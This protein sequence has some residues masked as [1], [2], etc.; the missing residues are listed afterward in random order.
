[1][2]GLDAV[3]ALIDAL[4]AIETPYML[5][6]SLASNLYGIARSTQDADL[7]V[8]LGGGDLDQLHDCQ[9]SSG[10]GRSCRRFARS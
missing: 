7:V 3:A 1:M 10:V 6:G 9:Y 2:S 4:E 5:V 8:D